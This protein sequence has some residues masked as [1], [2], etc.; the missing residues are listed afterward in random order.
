[1]RNFFFALLLVAVSATISAQTNDRRRP[2]PEEIEQRKE[3]LINQLDLT[4]E[5]T[6]QLAEL[7]A[8][9]KAEREATEGRPS[10][11]QMMAYRDSVEAILTEDQLAQ[12]KELRADRRGK[13]KARRHDRQGR[14]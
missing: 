1:M 8:E 7:R 13:S 10:R 14:Q 3:Q 5:Q 6:S 12:L 11:E 4:P 2:S 9:W